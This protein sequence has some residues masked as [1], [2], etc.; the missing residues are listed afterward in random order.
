MDRSFFLTQLE[1]RNVHLAAGPQAYLLATFKVATIMRAKDTPKA[2]PDDKCW[3]LIGQG[4]YIDGNATLE[5]AMPLFEQA[6]HTFIP[7][8]TITGEGQPPELWG[9]LFQVDALKAMNRALSETA[10]EEHS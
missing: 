7:V 6:G 10:A 3:D 4:V 9:A 1:R 2:A 5:Q 8:V